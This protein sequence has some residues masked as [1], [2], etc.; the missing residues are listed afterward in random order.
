MLETVIDVIELGVVGY[1]HMKTSNARDMVVEYD[2]Q[3]RL[4]SA[5]ERCTREE[6]GEGCSPGAC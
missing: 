6:D 2:M 5:S 3:D 1:S 4:V